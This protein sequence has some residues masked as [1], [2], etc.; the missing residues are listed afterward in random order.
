MNVLLLVVAIALPLGY[1][2]GEDEYRKHAQTQ[3]ISQ[4][5]GVAQATFEEIL[6]TKSKRDVSFRVK[7]RYEVNGLSYRVTTTP[8]DQQGALSYAAQRNVEVAYS[9]R[10]P[11]IGMLKRYYDFQRE[12][13]N[14]AQSLT[15][16]SVFSLALALPIG[17]GISWRLG[18]L[19]RKKRR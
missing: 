11:S 9:T 14:L 8:T 10:N 2:F 12:H 19:K 15:V 5:P 4:H 13:G 17:F 6:A 1:L 16:T 3:E 18:W 7:F